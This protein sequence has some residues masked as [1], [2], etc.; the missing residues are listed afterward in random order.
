MS[1]L[2]A[3]P[4]PASANTQALPRDATLVELRPDVL[5][6]ATRECLLPGTRVALSIGLEGQPLALELAVEALLVIAK[7]R[8]GYQFNARF[9]LATLSEAD[10]HLIQLFIVKGRGAPVLLPAEGR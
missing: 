8:A 9:A 6:I 10:R 5:T 4:R 2:S 1:K 3:T 7:D